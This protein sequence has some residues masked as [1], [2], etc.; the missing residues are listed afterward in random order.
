MILTN[1]LSYLF[2]LLAGLKIPVLS[3]LI[4]KVYCKIYPLNLQEAE[5]TDYKCLQEL[6]LRNLKSGARTVQGEFV[7]PVDGVLRSASKINSDQQLQ[8]KNKFYSISDLLGVANAWQEFSGGMIYNL[9]L[10]PADY[11]HVHAPCDMKITKIKYFP[12]GLLPVNDFLLARV[13]NLFAV[14]ERV[15]LWL[16]TK[17]GQAALVLVGAFNVGKIKVERT[18]FYANQLCYRFKQEISGLA[19]N[20]FKVGERIASFMLGSSVIL[21]T[22]DKHPCTGKVDNKVVRFGGGLEQ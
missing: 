1:I 2:G 14:N 7:S 16:E 19:E 18:D 6:F 20:D 17:W 4:I 21:C 8:V 11:H 22:D 10:S 13:N 5:N 3:S 12:G 15:I 9:Y